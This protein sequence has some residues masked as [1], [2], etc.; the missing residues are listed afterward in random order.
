[1][2]HFG[3]Q[4]DFV[5]PRVLCQINWVKDFPSN[6]QFLALIEFGTNTIDE[7]SDEMLTFFY[8]LGEE[9][10]LLDSFLGFGRIWDETL[11]IQHGVDV[12]W[13]KLYDLTI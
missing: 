8:Q 1:M 7:F 13:I 6:T 12:D 2:K 5:I 4:F 10:Q 9:Y 3:I 11:W